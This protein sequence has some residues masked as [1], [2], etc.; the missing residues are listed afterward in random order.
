MVWICWLYSFL[1]SNRLT[2][3]PFIF[4]LV[5]S[6]YFCQRICSFVRK[7]HNII[8]QCR[9]FRLFMEQL[10]CGIFTSHMKI[11]RQEMGV[12]D[13]KTSNHIN[14]ILRL[15]AVSPSRYIKQQITPT[16]LFLLVLAFS[17]QHYWIRINVSYRQTTTLKTMKMM[18]VKEKK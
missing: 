17:F 8:S 14:S 2:C 7:C 13:S 4:L 1:N 11:K 10:K 16:A 5:C 9:F 18:T 6:S 15:I 12:R 3:L